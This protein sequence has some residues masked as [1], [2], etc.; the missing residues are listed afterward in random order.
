MIK[1]NRFNVGDQVFHITP[2][3]PEG[4]VIDAKYSLLTGSWEYQVTFGPFT[5]SLW[6]YDIELKQNRS[7]NSSAHQNVQV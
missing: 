7:F 5:E 6:Y 4:I 3:S 1:P 2:E